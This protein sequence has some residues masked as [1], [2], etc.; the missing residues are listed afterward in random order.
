MYPDCGPVSFDLMIDIVVVLFEAFAMILGRSLFGRIHRA[1]V[2][3]WNSLPSEVRLI[4]TVS[5]G[6]LFLFL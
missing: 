1:T 2:D 5:Q 4:W 3:I 6:Y